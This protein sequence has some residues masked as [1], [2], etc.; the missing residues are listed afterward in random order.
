LCLAWKKNNEHLVVKVILELHMAFFPFVLQIVP[1]TETPLQVEFHEIIFPMSHNTHERGSKQE[2]CAYF[3]PVMQYVQ[4]WFQ[5][6]N[7]Q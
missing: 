1:H 5:T 2:G 7:T 4:S 3:T 6:R